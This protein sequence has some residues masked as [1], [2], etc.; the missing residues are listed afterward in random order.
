[1][2]NSKQ[3]AKKMEYKASVTIDATRD[4]VWKVFTAPESWKDWYG[5]NLKAVEPGWKHNAALVWALGDPSKITEFVPQEK[6]AF[7]GGSGMIVTWSFVSS[8]DQKTIVRMEKDFSHSHLS[9]SD[10]SAVILQLEEIL[11]GLKEYVESE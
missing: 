4:A 9:V 6:V 1:L 10:P 8:G 11:E 7:G 3:E 5:G 2:Q